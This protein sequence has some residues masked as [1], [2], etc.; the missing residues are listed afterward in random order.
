MLHFTH[1]YIH[2]TH[3]YTYMYIVYLWQSIALHKYLLPAFHFIFLFISKYVDLS[4][5]QFYSIYRFL[6]RGFWL[7]SADDTHTLIS[8]GYQIN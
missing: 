8:E 1:T 5:N 7:V 2:T 3:I 6:L 4:T